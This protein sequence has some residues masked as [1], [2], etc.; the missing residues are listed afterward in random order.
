M[1][2]EIYWYIE[3]RVIGS[4]FFGDVAEH[5]IS[6]HGAEVEIYIKNGVQP[7]F[8]LVDVRDIAKYPTNIKD[9][10]EAMSKNPE[11]SNNLAWTILVTDSRFVNFISSVVSNFF[12]IG[13]RTCKTIEEAEIFIA[14]HADDLA[15]ALEARK[16]SAQVDSQ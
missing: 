15:P 1:A 2:H 12:K 6:D 5:E 7:M 10:L 13:I 4:R 3:K 11:N 9:L 14:H 8:L 16:Q